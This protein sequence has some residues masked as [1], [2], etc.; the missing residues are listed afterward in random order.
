[1][2]DL[3]TPADLSRE[4]GI[5]QRPI[6]VFLRREYGTLN[7]PETRWLLTDER[8]SA[9]RRHFSAAR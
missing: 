5:G 9:V 6:R 7:P 3:R 4:L 2:D 1:M 8:A